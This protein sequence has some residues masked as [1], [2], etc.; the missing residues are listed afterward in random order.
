MNLIRF[1]EVFCKHET[2]PESCDGSG[3]F[4]L[5]SEHS[6]SNPGPK[7]YLHS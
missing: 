4:F 7:R 1:K 6:A 2:K 5:F 3:S